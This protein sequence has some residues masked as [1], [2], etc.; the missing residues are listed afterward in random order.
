M[1]IDVGEHEIRKQFH[2]NLIAENLIAAIC[3]T[4][5]PPLLYTKIALHTACLFGRKDIV[6]YPHTNINLTRIILP[7]V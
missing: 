4:Y 5:V 1:W 3:D 6:S 7:E 2:P